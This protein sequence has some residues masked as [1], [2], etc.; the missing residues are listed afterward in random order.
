VQGYF[1][2]GRNFCQKA[3]RKIGK[4][5]NYSVDDPAAI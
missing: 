5:G 1:L 3:L 4:I 2:R